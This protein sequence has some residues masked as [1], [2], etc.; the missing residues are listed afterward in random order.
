MAPDFPAEAAGNALA[1]WYAGTDDPKSRD[2][3]RDKR[4]SLPPD[5]IN[6]VPQWIPMI[7][8]VGKERK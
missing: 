4:P 8:H 5:F 1:V 7:E 3:R 2:Q 6:L